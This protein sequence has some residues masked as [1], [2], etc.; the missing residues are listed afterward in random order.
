MLG[1]TKAYQAPELFVMNAK[2]SK[3]ADVF[4]FGVIVLELI[5]MENPARLY[6]R[7]WPKIL[8]VK[9]IPSPLLDCLSSTLDE[10]P[11][12]RKNFSDIYEMLES[13]EAILC[14]TEPLTEELAERL[15]ENTG[16]D[17][18]GLSVGARMDNNSSRITTNGT[19][20]LRS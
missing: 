17:D 7:L 1:G 18:E 19:S 10:D 20:R 4:A 12:F 3:K 9:E 14:E 8:H 6:D 2:F 5:M 15:M 16:E 13:A 11:H